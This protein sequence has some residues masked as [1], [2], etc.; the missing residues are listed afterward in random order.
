[1]REPCSRGASAGHHA[2]QP[3]QA[4]GRSGATV[5]G[6][7]DRQAFGGTGAA[8]PVIGQGTWMLEKADRRSAL[9]TLWRGLDLGLVH[10]AT[11][12]LYGNG[13]VEELVGG[14]IAGR[15]DHVYLV[16]KVRPHHASA[17][18]TVTACERSLRRLGTDHLDCY[19]LHW[20][21]SHAIADTIA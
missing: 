7:M 20:P 14:A 18:G 12:E 1:P 13:G 4:R 15:R 8:V 10:I 21:G 17:A 6:A 19:L 9:A 11:A 3:R 2:V 5:R 16:S